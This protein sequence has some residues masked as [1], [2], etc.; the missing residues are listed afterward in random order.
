MKKTILGLFLLSV[1]FLTMGKVLGAYTE[2]GHS[3]F[4][5]ITFVDSK[6]RLLKNYS[7]KEINKYY[8]SLTKKTFGWSTYYLNLDE[9]ASYEGVIIF[10]RANSTSAPISFDYSLKDVTFSEV[11]VTVTGSVSAKVSGTIKKITLGASGEVSAK[12]T[13]ESSTTTEEKTA[14]S[15]MIQPG[16]KLTMMVTGVCYVTTAVSIYRFLGIKV[17]KGAWEKIDVD[18]IVYEVREEAL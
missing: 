11:S 6:V 7:E 16:T 2:T 10:S 3:D 15:F 9:K 14:I 17:R 13:K 5:K 18:T 4:R 1:M 12:R 8:S